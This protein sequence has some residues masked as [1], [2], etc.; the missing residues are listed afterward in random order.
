MAIIVTCFVDNSAKSI[1]AALVPFG[2]D[3][4]ASSR[5]VRESMAQTV[6]HHGQGLYN[7]PAHLTFRFFISYILSMSNA[8]LL[9][10]P[11]RYPIPRFAAKSPRDV[12]ETTGY[13]PSNVEPG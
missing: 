8:E 9:F 6:L 2:A 13:F 4:T 11:A 12:P 10:Q 1:L 5:L 7:T 3:T